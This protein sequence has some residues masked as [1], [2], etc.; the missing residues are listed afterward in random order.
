MCHFLHKVQKACPA[1][2]ATD[3]YL[4]RYMECNVLYLRTRYM[5]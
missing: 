1:K 3:V 5:Y 2:R 4:D